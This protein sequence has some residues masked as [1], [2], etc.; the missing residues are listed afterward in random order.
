MPY[1]S[2]MLATFC[3]VFPIAETRVAFR[4]QKDLVCNHFCETRSEILFGVMGL[5]DANKKLCADFQ[6]T[7]R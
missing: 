7:K 6:T 1:V 2:P 5:S 3:V 4:R